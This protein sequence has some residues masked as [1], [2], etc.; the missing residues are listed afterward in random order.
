MCK[1]S[2]FLF[3]F[4]LSFQPSEGGKKNVPPNVLA[5]DLLLKKKSEKK[6]QEKSLSSINKTSCPAPAR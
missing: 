6:K 2:T 4:F 3:S 5:P 1:S